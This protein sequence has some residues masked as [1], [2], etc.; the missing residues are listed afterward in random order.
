MRPAPYTTLQQAQGDY[1]H[2]A[3]DDRDYFSIDLY[4]PGKITIDP[5]K[6]TGQHGKKGSVSEASFAVFLVR[7]L[8]NRV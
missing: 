3:K 7:G 6:H 2:Y 5:S 4:E 1:H 8:P